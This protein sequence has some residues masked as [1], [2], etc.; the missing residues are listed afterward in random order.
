MRINEK[1]LWIIAHE[2][3]QQFL[4]EAEIDAVRRLRQ[5]NNPAPAKL[6]R[7]FSWQIGGVMISWGQYLQ[8]LQLNQ[9]QECAENVG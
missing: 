9:K 2:R 1:T 8:H 3:E 4:K 5:K 7:R 6:W